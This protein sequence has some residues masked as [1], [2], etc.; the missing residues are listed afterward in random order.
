MTEATIDLNDVKRLAAALDAVDLE[1]RDRATLHAVFALAGRAVADSHDDEVSGFS[2]TNVPVVSSNLLSS[3]LGPA[4]VDQ[5]GLKI[6][7]VQGQ[8]D[9]PYVEGSDFNGP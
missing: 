1:D 4:P 3:F 5:P 6:N 2:L 8:P 9:H 7:V